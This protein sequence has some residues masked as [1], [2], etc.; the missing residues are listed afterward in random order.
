[1]LAV[2]RANGLSIVAV[3][4]VPVHIVRVEV[5]VPRVVRVVRVERTRPVVAVVACVVQVVVVAIARRREKN[6]AQHIRQSPDTDADTNFAT[7]K[8][9][10]AF[11]V[12][13]LHSCVTDCLW[14]W[15]V[16]FNFRFQSSRPPLIPQGGGCCAAA[17]Q[18]QI[19]KFQKIKLR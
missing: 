16:F 2:H 5:R 7:T 12:S 4:V 3:V 10:S 17:Q 15:L 11:C 8:S 9:I 6:N 18:F 14:I 13:F 1:M 19:S